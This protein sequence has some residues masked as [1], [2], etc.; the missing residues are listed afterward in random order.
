MQTFIVQVYSQSIACSTASAAVPLKK[1]A[2]EFSCSS[3]MKWHFVAPNRYPKGL[4]WLDKSVNDFSRS[5][6]FPSLVQ[7]SSYQFSITLALCIMFSNGKMAIHYPGKMISVLRLLGPVFRRRLQTGP[8]GLYEFLATLLNAR[9]IF[10]VFSRANKRL[11]QLNE[12]LASFMRITSS[13]GAI[14][15]KC[16]ELPLPRTG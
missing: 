6:K 2:T 10:C 11:R 16:L 1:P 8:L 9:Q 5:S 7:L 3:A 13:F 15:A 12:F 4:P 14:K